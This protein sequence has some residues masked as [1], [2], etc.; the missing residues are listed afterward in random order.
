MSHI[1]PRYV[2]KGRIESENTELLDTIE[3]EL[4]DEGD[5]VLG[6]EY[7]LS[8]SPV[9]NDESNETDAE[10]LSGRMTFAPDDREFTLDADGNII[11]VEDSSNYDSAD[12]FGPAEAAQ[13][14]YQ[15]IVSHDLAEKAD[16]WRVGVYQSPEGGVTASDVKEWYEADE[17]RQPEREVEQPDGT[18]S[19]EK[20][21]PNSFDPTNHIVVEETG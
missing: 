12:I 21:I 13:Q 1:D 6:N 11:E 8:R 19:T 5:P 15:T 3:S 17:T 18:T 4:P 16:G 10:V 9:L 7:D 2:V 14:F 20:Y